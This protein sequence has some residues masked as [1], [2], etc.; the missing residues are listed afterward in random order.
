MSPFSSI[1]PNSST[2]SYC[3]I[4]YPLFCSTA[5]S[6]CFATHF[7]RLNRLQRLRK[8]KARYTQ[9]QQ[10]VQI[11]SRLRIY[12]KKQFY[13]QR[14]H[15]FRHMGERRSFGVAQFCGSI[16]D[17][18]RHSSYFFHIITRQQHPRSWLWLGSYHYSPYQEGIR[19]QRDRPLSKFDPLCSEISEEAR[20]TY[21]V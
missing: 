1:I 9:W 8:A 20:V 4:N 5:D 14:P 3:F 21:S 7:V 12:D 6:I 15:L 11:L 16:E 19:C 17:F 2:A 18:G 13:S 10:G